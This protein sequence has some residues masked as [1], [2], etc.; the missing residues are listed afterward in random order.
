MTKVVGSDSLGICSM[1]AIWPRHTPALK[2]MEFLHQ[3][4]PIIPSICLGRSLKLYLIY[5]TGKSCGFSCCVGALIFCIQHY[6]GLII[7]LEALG[8]NLNVLHLCML[9]FWV[10]PWREVINNYWSIRIV[11]RFEWRVFSVAAVDMK[12]WKVLFLDNLTW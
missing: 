9:N 12:W 6:L 10:L 7:S 2:C 8:F 11:E 4:P 3:S 1:W 5:V